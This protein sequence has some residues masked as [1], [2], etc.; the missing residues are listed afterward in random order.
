[1]T[2]LLIFVV[3]QVCYFFYK[4]ISYALTLFWFGVSNAFSAQVSRP[5]GEAHAYSRHALPWECQ[6]RGRD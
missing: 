4:N 5:E 6:E 1:M 2:L 3:W